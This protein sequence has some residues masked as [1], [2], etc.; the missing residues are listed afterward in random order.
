MLVALEVRMNPKI[1]ITLYFIL[2][3]LAFSVYA[4]QS[5][6]RQALL[7]EFKKYP[8][9]EIQDI[10]KLVYQAAMGNEHIMHDPEINRKYLQEELSTLEAS[11]DEPLLEYL[12]SDSSIARLNL[13][14]FKALKGNQ[15]KLLELMNKTT[16]TIKPS[17]EYL[18]HLWKEAEDLA[19]EGKIPFHKKEMQEYFK[20]LEKQ[21]FPPV[22]HSKAVFKN[23]HPSYR[24]VIGKQISIK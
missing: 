5:S 7:V 17:V 22:H 13:R 1:K 23:Y 15:E 19:F 9:L 6:C 10:Y 4:Q 14:P 2:S 12:T 11:S 3:L 20:Q 18:K 24:I 16:K 8:L 21:N